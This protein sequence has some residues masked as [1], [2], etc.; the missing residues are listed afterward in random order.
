MKKKIEFSKIITLLAIMIFAGYGVWSGIEYYRL[1]QQ[2][3]ALG[4]T[5]PDPTLAVTC[6]T[7][8]IAS[9]GS[10]C[11]YQFGLKNSRNKYGISSEGEPFVVKNDIADED[12]FPVQDNFEDIDVEG[13]E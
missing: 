4:S 5:M 11:L 1:C 9:I 7:T 3:I 10:Y 8:I 6:V 2:A 12:S 13:V